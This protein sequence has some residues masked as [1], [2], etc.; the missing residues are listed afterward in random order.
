MNDDNT[1]A[2]ETTIAACWL[3]PLDPAPSVFQLI[4]TMSDFMNRVAALGDAISL[5]E[6]LEDG[7]KWLGV[8]LS[9]LTREARAYVDAWEAA[10]N[11]AAVQTAEAAA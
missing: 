1:T 9:D 5:H 4:E 8:M 6:E 7:P 10:R 3:S 11:P 2:P